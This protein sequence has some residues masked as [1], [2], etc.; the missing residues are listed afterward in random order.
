MTQQEYYDAME[1]FIDKNGNVKPQ[2]NCEDS[3]NGLS[4]DNI[5]LMFRDLNGFEYGN[6]DLFLI[7]E[8]MPIPG[9]LYRTPGNTYG[10]QSWD[11][12]LRVA[13]TFIIFKN[14]FGPRK[15]IWYAIK[16]LFFMTT[17]PG[18]GLKAWLGRFVHMWMV[19]FIA[20]FPPLK[21]LFFLPF[22]CMNLL[23]TPD[24]NDSSGAQ[25]QMTFQYVFKKLY[26]INWVFKR[27][28]NKFTSQG[29]DVLEIFTTYYDHTHPFTKV[30]KENG[31]VLK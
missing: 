21:Y 28:L 2:L 23:F 31:V 1:K 12:Y 6:A 7:A 11:D 4:Y 29:T 22:L 18:A 19:M 14:T 10:Q 25:L 13:C 16:H 24:A 30:L 5:D 27:W 3:G 17:E 26:G 15:I 20:A 8:C 9:L